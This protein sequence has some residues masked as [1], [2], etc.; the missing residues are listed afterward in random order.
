[1][2]KNIIFDF[3]GVLL[4]LAPER[5]KAAYRSIGF[6]GIDRMLNLAH[7]QGVLDKMER[8]LL[9]FDEYCDAIRAEIRQDNALSSIDL[10]MPTNRQIVHAFCEM[11]DGIPAERL[12]I[13]AQ[14]KKEGYHVSAL[15]NTNHVH[16]GYCQRY[17]IECGYVPDQLFERIWLSCDMHLVKPDAEIFRRV[18]A[19]SG[20]NPSETIFVDD[21]AENCRVAS[22][23]GIQTFCP[24]VRSDWREQLRAILKCH[25]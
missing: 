7:Q 21:N 8:G 15:S 24:P 19:E 1:M 14:L 3:G 23:F 6:K 10:P 18:L 22:E 5:C 2:I 16:W 13:I 25:N 17:F 11:A 4:D 9:T 20:Y 12:D